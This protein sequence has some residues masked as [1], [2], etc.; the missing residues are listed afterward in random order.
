MADHAL[1]EMLQRLEHLLTA[2]IPAKRGLYLGE[3]DP[4]VERREAISLL[5][6]Q[7]DYFISRQP[8][9]D[10]LDERLRRGD[11][12]GLDRGDEVERW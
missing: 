4:A 2:P 10:A 3:P 5:E 11:F 6:A 8:G 1:N 7:I 12:A 9:N